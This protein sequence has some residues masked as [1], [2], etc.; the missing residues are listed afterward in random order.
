[1]DG[2]QRNAAIAKPF[3]D[4]PDVLL[5]VGVVDVLAGGK[6][7]NR[8]GAATRESVEQAGMQPLLHINIC[9]YRVQHKGSTS[10]PYSSVP[11]GQA[12]VAAIARPK[13]LT[14]LGIDLDTLAV[15]PVAV[16]V[17]RVT[18]L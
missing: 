1:M 12:V 18:H 3:G 10:M 8:L 9:R 17:Q 16:F 15:A 6:N 13:A 14:R 11:D 5:A 7:L 4:L 2:M